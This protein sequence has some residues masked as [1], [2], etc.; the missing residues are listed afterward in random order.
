MD[1]QFEAYLNNNSIAIRNMVYAA[2]ILP[3]NRYAL[4]EGKTYGDPSPQS[5]LR[6]KIVRISGNE[7]AYKNLAT[8]KMN[9]KNVDELLNVW[10][11]FGYK[12]ISQV[13]GVLAVIK[14]YLTPL[15]GS[16]LVAILINWVL[17]NV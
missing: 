7:I 2:V 9:Y 14:K 10:N 1:N 8:E 15:I 11:N 17:K 3:L 5:K 4:R 16:A 12:E 13:D 6:F